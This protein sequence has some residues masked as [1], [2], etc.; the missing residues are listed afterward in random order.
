MSYSI[1]ETVALYLT[2]DEVLVLDSF[3][4][5]FD[6]GEETSTALFIRNPSERAAV[7]ALQSALERN[8][9]GTFDP[10]Y[11]QMLA[12]AQRRLCEKV[13]L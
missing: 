3:L 13:G 10:E 9:V 1:S 12:E 2:S 5:Q 8:L 6:E 7:W 11:Q 4:S